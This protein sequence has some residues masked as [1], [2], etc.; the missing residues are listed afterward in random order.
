LAVPEGVE[1]TRP[2]PDAGGILEVNDL[3]RVTLGA[4]DDPDGVRFASEVA[5]RI[6][7]VVRDRRSGKITTCLIA[8]PW[9]SGDLETVDRGTACALRWVTSRGL[10]TLPCIFE[11][12]DMTPQGLRV[13]RVRVV[14]ELRRAERRQFVRVPWA[15]PVDLVIQRD[16]DA[17]PPQA[18]QR[19]FENGIRAKLPDL[20]ERISAEVVNLS[21]GGL[22]CLSP[23]PALPPGLPL[24][25]RFTLEDQ[26]FQAASHVIRSERHL[27]PQPELLEADE[28]RHQVE[29]AITFDEPGGIHGER[30]RPLLFAAQLRARRG[31]LA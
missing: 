20:P 10:C 14:G 17:L 3:V 9:Y 4:V 24:L 26:H 28:E 1:V 5:S 27:T 18:R 22:R 2:L 29:S 25:V 19:A 31:N 16:L 8:A 7:D 11:D 6:E 21:E 30:L 12:Q 23:E 13:W 15:V